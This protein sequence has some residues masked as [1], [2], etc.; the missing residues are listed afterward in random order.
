MSQIL[1]DLRYG[2][3]MF[4]RSPIFT[5][6]AILSL[7]IGIGV[8]SA[9]FSV[10]DAFLL[11]PLPGA[12]PGQLASLY[13]K[14]P[15]GSD[16]LSYPD[17][18][19]V[20]Q[21]ASAFSGVLAAA[22]HGAFLKTGGEPVL[23]LTN[24]VSENYFEV[25]GLK[26]AAGRTFEEEEGGGAGSGPSVIISYALWQRQFGRDPGLI[27]N[28]IILNNKPYTVAGVAPKG[29]RGLSRFVA[30]DAW[31][32]AV[33]EIS[34]ETQKR[35]IREFDVVARLA[36]G[37]TAAQ[38]QA[39]LDVIGKRLAKEYPV[40][41]RDTTFTLETE[42][43]RIRGATN[44]GILILSIVSLV[45][46]ICCA[47]V[48]GLLL[49]RSETRRREIALRRA[50][51]ATRFRLVRQLLTEGAI[52]TF[53]GTALGLLLADWLIGLQ[54]S[55]MPAEMVPVGLDLR[56]DARV[57]AFTIASAVAT[58]LF[59]GLL[60]AFQGS[61]KSLASTLQS[62]EGHSRSRGGGLGMRNVF[63]VA[64]IALSV[65]LL[66]CAGLFARSFVFSRTIQLG[67]DMKKNL[68]VLEV[69]P[70]VT[71]HSTAKTAAFF[72]TAKER[73]E[74]I[75]GVKGV[76]KAR[77][78]P[79]SPTGGGAQVKFSIPGVELPGQQPAVFVKFNSVDANYFR[80]VGTQ[81][82][83]GRD[84][85]AADESAGS[86]VAVISLQMA[87]QF[88]EDRDPIG[89][90]FL[91]DD[92]D[93]QIIGVAQDVTI[94]DVHEAFEPYVYLP[95]WQRPDGEG[96]LIV[97]TERDPLAMA[98]T[99]RDVIRSVDS[100]AA[101]L[102]TS[103]GKEILISA[104]W[105]EQIAAMVF[106]DLSLLGASLAAIG[107]YG[108]LSFVINRRRRELGV[109]IALGAGR[110]DILRLVLGQG[111]KLALWGTGLG[112]VIAF[113]GS[114]VLANSLYGVQARDALTFA[115]ASVLAV[116][117]SLAASYLPAR[118]AM[119]LDP[120]EVLRFD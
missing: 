56:I 17:Y 74:G 18:D 41:N 68:L 72:E 16:V 82:L 8:N 32:P 73:L 40:T 76:S 117:I 98:G 99:V 95:F 103:T 120:M 111:L 64:E 54:P 75:H 50:M 106:G 12:A 52:L 105:D 1:Q 3:R 66:I 87:K 53:G 58:A 97:E 34:F 83:K 30:T 77:R 93:Y 23:L 60:P 63:V 59:V 114:R 51:G 27:G 62:Y 31:M 86:R 101:I 118:K 28:S 115:G 13:T 113:A 37:A 67:L 45:L 109:R 21:G 85:S 10:V 48:G 5:A 22:G 43:E 25:L 46:L 4:A 94:N 57:V 36:P 26:L 61:Q 80:C 71:E 110:R 15:H 7:A 104:M 102:K 55:L 88:W 6:T 69:A 33:K 91:A 84:F 65:A 112:L 107:L 42:A 90:H 92:N 29:Y 108:V 49:A 14:T 11:R 89:A 24:D 79:L 96:T 2:V 39:E 81:I 20:R 78:Y 19:D 70:D 44:G 47:N 9:A 35:D 38:A 119:R 100:D 116:A